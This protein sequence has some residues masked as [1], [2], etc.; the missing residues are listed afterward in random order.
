MIEAYAEIV[1]SLLSLNQVSIPKYL[2]LCI[3]YFF[4]TSKYVALHEL[5][6]L[7]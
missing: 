1:I 5:P 3:R 2:L 6:T 7:K 4:M